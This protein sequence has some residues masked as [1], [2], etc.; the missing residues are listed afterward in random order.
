MNSTDQEVD[1]VEF[2]RTSVPEDRWVH[3]Q[4]VMDLG[5]RL[6]STYDLPEQSLQQAALLHDNARGLPLEEQESLARQFR[7]ELDRIERSVPGLLH[8]P[9][10]A[11]RMVEELGFSPENPLLDVVANHSTGAPH[12]EPTLSGLLVADFA[13][14]NRE[15]PEAETI[16]E[17]IGSEPL[18]DLVHDTLRF[19]IK[20]L[21]DDSTPLHPR[22]VR[23]FNYL[24]E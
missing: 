17:R 22:S 1:S 24:C 4:G 14:P 15:Y 20:F 19:K 16:R 11:Q 21:L 23:A 2:V 9:A 12:P 10:G 7:G 8:A 18:V 6:A 13:E 3:T 5:H